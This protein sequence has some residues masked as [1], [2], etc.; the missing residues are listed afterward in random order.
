MSNGSR[1]GSSHSQARVDWQL[2]DVTWDAIRLTADRIPRSSSGGTATL[3]RAAV[4]AAVL[5]SAP[6]EQTRRLCRADGCQEVPLHIILNNI[7]IQPPGR[8]K[9][10]NPRL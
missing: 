8:N 10:I 1:G 7:F 2:H 4:V 3:S 5:P 6:A 9:F